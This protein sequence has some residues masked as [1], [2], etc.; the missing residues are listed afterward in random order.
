MTTSIAVRERT[1]DRPGP[2]PLPEALLRALDLKIGR[3]I[4]G[5]L[6]GEHRIAWNGRSSD[7]TILPPG[8]YFVQ[9]E[10]G[11]FAFT[12]KLVRIRP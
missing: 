6:A 2:G 1:P 3:R 8:V 5:L 7:G 4:E 12:E 10:A 11:P 9:L